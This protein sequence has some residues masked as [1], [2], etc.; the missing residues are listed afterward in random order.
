MRWVDARVEQRNGDARAVEPVDLEVG[1]GSRQHAALARLGRLRRICD[2]H[3]IDPHDL[4]VVLEERG[5]RRVEPRR[6]SVDH[7]RVAVLG[8]NPRANRR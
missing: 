2:P 6:E 4:A 1:D 8:R 7:A 3:G 5:R